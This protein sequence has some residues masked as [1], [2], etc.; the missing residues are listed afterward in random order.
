VYFALLVFYLPESP[1][2]LV[3]D[4]KISEARISLQWLRGKDDVSGENIAN[5][6]KYLITFIVFI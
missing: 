6:L 2:W 1:R 4:G 3:S 5:N